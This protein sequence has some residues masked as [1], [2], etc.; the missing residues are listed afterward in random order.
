MDDPDKY[1]KAGNNI[2]NRLHLS[3]YP[4]AIKYIKGIDE[5]PE[6][7]IRPSTFGKKMTLCQAFTQARRWGAKIAMTAEDNLCTP[8]S[9]AHRWADVSFDDLV[10]SQVIQGWHKDSDAEKKRISAGIKMLGEEGLN[11]IDGY[12][13]LVCSSLNET[14]FEPDSILVYCDAVQLTHIIQAL[15]YEYKHVP[16]SSFDGFAESCI[17]GGLI[18]FATGM[19]QVVI[20]GSGDRSLAGTWDSEL[21]I[22]I[23]GFLVFYVLENLFKT[24]G[25][26]NIGYPMRSLM[27]T[28]LDEN[29][30]PGFKFLSEKMDKT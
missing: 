24:G 19:P 18:P 3:T 1:R 4:V 6:G 27:P 7:F 5:I 21:A 2:Y 13:G 30:T 20:P 8:S 9:A 10:E 28:D 26:M 22:G 15:C 11:K 17:K 12:H 23:P 16:T 25:I 29:I 14:V